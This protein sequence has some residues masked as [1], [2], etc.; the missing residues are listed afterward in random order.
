[1]RKNIMLLAGMAIILLLS[2]GWYQY[3]MA[4]RTDEYILLSSASLFQKG[5]QT[6][7]LKN[8]STYRSFSSLTSFTNMGEGLSRYFGMPKG[9]VT[10]DPNEQPIYT[11]RKNTSDGTTLSFY[12]A[13]FQDKSTYLIFQVEKTGQ[14]GAIDAKSV[15]RVKLRMEKQLQEMGIK[16]QW[17]IMLQEPVGE[18]PPRDRRLVFTKLAQS[19][20]AREISKYTDSGSE[21]IS[22]HSEIIKQRVQQG[23]IN[24]QVAVH[25]NS[26]SGQSRLTIG[27]PMISI[28]F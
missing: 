15:D 8:N 27:I 25:Q 2:F 19:L 18:I 13:G 23:D 1:M 16:P 9:T 21:S 6:I 4:N 24:V 26:I 10:Y 12:L 17:N 20:R 11:A 14:T 7:I 3:A 22:Y 28:E 5:P